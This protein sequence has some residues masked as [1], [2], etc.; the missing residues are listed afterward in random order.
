MHTHNL[1][2]QTLSKT[3]KGRCQKD[4]VQCQRDYPETGREDSWT[5]SNTLQKWKQVSVELQLCNNVQQ[6][7]SEVI[8]M[9]ANVQKKKIHYEIT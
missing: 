3:D 2:M 9:L 5:E 8:A 1:V 6:N 7:L 4:Y